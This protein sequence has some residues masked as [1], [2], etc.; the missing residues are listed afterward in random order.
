MN[1]ATFVALLIGGHDLPGN[2]QAP[3]EPTAENDLNSF[4]LR[5]DELLHCRGEPSED[6]PDAPTSTE[7]ID[8]VF[9]QWLPAA[10]EDMVLTG[11]LLASTSVVPLQSAAGGGMS[12]SL[13]ELLVK[14]LVDG[15]DATT[16]TSQMGEFLRWQWQGRGDPVLSPTPRSTGEPPPLGP[17]NAPEA[18]LPGIRDHPDRWARSE[19]AEEPFEQSTRWLAAALF[20]SGVSQEPMGLRR[21]EVSRRRPE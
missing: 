13:P 17:R 20:F 15:L 18:L 8:Q 6:A 1:A 10:L 12:H 9:R 4:L 14:D 19:I 2:E 3:A 5:Q 11:K 16:A 7:L 21:R